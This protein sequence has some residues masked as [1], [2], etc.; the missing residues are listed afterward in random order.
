MWHTE[1]RNI[2]NMLDKRI[3]DFNAQAEQLLQII[4]SRLQCGQR[5]AALQYLIFK[6]KTL[7]EQGVMNGRLYEKE[8]VFPY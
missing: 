8:G 4:E 2:N 7:Y 1:T 6:F 5:D 3:L